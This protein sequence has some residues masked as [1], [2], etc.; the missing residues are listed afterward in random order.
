M[1]ILL[2][3][4]ILLRSIEPRHVQ[5]VESVQAIDILR[6]QDHELVIVPQVLYEFWTVATRPVANNGMGMAA[7]DALAEVSAMRRLF[8]LLRDERSIYGIWERLVASE[9]VL[10]KPAHDA[11]IAAAMMRH[12]VSYLLTFNAADFGKY[13]RCLVLTPP[14]VMQNAKVD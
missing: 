10:G 3:T 5:H 14:Q 4:N 9:G 11:R 6:R 1:R 7:G 13:P 2:D 12:D 8:R